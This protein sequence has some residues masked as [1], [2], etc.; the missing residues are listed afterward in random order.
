MFE[1]DSA[2]PE[3]AVEVPLP[4][5][6][7]PASADIRRQ[8]L[9]IEQVYQCS[10]VGLVLMDMDY[11]FV[12]INER[13]AEINGLP[14]EAHIGRTLREVAPELADGIME[15]YRPVYERGE[16]VLNV[17]L[18]GPAPTG[19][20]ARRRW[21]A[22][23]F[24]FRSPTGEVAGLIGAVVDISERVQQEARLRDSEERFRT[25]FETVTDAIFVLDIAAG[26]LVDVNR[27]A[28]DMFG[29][30]HDELLRMSIADLSENE[31]P[32]TQADADA[33]TALVLTGHV[34]AFEWR[35]KRRDG[36]LFWVD[37]GCRTATFG[38]RRYLLATVR[39]ID[40]RKSAE[41][42]LTAMARL[43]LLTG[44]ANRGTFVTVLEHA[45]ADARRHGRG[46]AVFFLDLDHFKD[47]NDTLGHPVGD[48]LL[49]QVGQRLCQ[50]VRA[51]DTIARFGGDEFAILMTDMGDPVDAEILA[52]R[53]VQSMELPFTVDGNRVHT[54]VSIGIAV[55]ESEA[56]AEALLSHAD[57]ALYRAK[58]EGRHIYRFFNDAMDREVRRRVHLVS[59]LRDAI[60]NGDLVLAWQPQVDLASG[61]ITGLEALVR[62][63]HPTH[64]LQSPG[65]FI[66]AA[67]Q[68]GLIV[69]L[70]RW[71]LVEACRQARQWLDAG[72]AP[73]RVAVNFSGLQFKMPGEVV[74][75][76]EAVLL[77]TGLPANMLEVELT[78]STL[79]ET[80][81]TNS[82]ILK[83]LR[84]LGITVAIDDF[85]TGYSS[86]AYLRRFP[87]DRIKLAQEFIVDIVTDANDAVI[88]QAAI[89]LA[90]TLGADMI[91]EGVETEHQL[92]LLKS[93]GCGAA[94]GYYFARPLP[95]DEI[96]PLLRRGRIDGGEMQAVE[97]VPTGAGDG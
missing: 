89:G 1:A 17:E 46:L 28:E 50:N 32:Y 6:S 15:L 45:L 92:A 86:L 33:K 11:R 68:S 54:G 93:W 16:P 34:P 55:Y 38:D 21:L 37:I 62:W 20:A 73:D 36:T 5:A 67:E 77:A 8:L 81:R 51:A 49:Q 41:E 64:G 60:G 3:A 23:F 79:M 91:A 27:R 10:P 4:A 12:R 29:Y 24:P 75:E 66:P 40:A 14:M 70:G 19:P 13:M 95:A 59:E 42:R 65:L 71:V 58:S 57:V 53:L 47:V 30:S 96:T 80:T 35:C 69:P 22:N 43:D 72:I 2:T 94:Q 83:E 78:E 31:P 74:R 39:N 88:V 82:G 25:I 76:I 84:A 9:E 52:Q 56:D 97:R 85:G 18:D 63:Q 61:R 44:L 48:R 26:A 87:V 90:R 7:L